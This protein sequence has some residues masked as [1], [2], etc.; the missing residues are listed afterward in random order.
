M[1]SS[2]ELPIEVG[3]SL[4]DT[5]PDEARRILNVCF[6]QGGN[7]AAGAR[8]WA[9][10]TVNRPIGRVATRRTAPEFY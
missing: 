1:G 8:S 6:E 10:T 9:A 7:I 5:S 3:Y 2:E 4:W